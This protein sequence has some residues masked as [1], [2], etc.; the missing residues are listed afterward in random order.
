MRKPLRVLTVEDSEN[1]ALLLVRQLERG[2]FDVDFKRVDTPEAMNEA[3]LAQTWDI[4]L[5]DHVMPNFSAPAALEVLRERDFDL[6]FIIV[7]GSISAELAVALMKAG[8]HDWISKDDL[9]RLVPVVE[10]ELRDVEDRRKRREAEEGLRRNEQRLRSLFETMTEGVVLIAPDGQIVQANATAEQILGLTRSEIEGRSYVAPEWAIIRPDGTPMPAEEMVGPRAMAER[11]S[12]RD[13]VMGVKRPDG[14]IVWINVSAAPLI[15]KSGELEG[16]VGTFTDITARKKAEEE[17]RKSE[18]RFRSIV[19]TTKEWI[20]IQDLQG[21]HTYNSPALKA[22]L[23]YSP[24]EFPEQD[25]MMLIHE[26]DRRKEEE[27]FQKYMAE[28]KGWTGWVSRWKNKDGT[29]RYLESAATPLFDSKGELT[30]YLGAERDIT[31]RIKAEEALRESEELYRTL[32]DTSPDAITLTDLQGKIVIC[33]NQTARLH[34]YGNPEAIQ[35]LAAFELIAPED[36]EKALTNLR[37]TLET[38]SVR[39]LEYILLRKDGSRFRGELSAAVLRDAAGNP[40]AFVG[41]TRD[42]TERKK[43]RDELDRLTTL[44]DET[45]S[46]ALVG[47][48]EIDVKNNTLFWT[49]ETYRIHEI[50]PSEYMPTVDTAIAFYAPESVPIIR[51]AVQKALEK[52]EEFNLELE[53]ITAK[54]RRISVQATSKAIWENGQI[55]K[56]LGAFQDI[57]ERKEAELELLRR[58][59]AAE[60]A[61]LKAQTYLDF[62]SHDLTNILSPVMM[63]S[64]MISTDPRSHPWVKETAT[65]V[66]KQIERAVS[67]VRNTRRLSESERDESKR[68]ETV[69]LLTVLRT[70]EEEIRKMYPNKR[71]NFERSLPSDGPVNAM[72][73]SYIQ[74]IIDEILDN[75]AKHG[76]SND[77]RI[78]ITVHPIEKLE[79]HGYWKVEIADYGPGIPDDMKKG[80][81]AEVFEP[82]NRMTRGIASSLSFMALVAEHI[83]GRLRIEDRVQGD[84][85]KG[86]KV[87]LLFRKVG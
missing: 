14:V 61:T 24:D 23:G 66:V 86:T 55:V 50:S 22:I 54:G 48:W 20:W 47:G 59:E 49:S 33:S 15:D 69:D 18:E 70:K 34:G 3:L 78:D 9:S 67:F 81:M 29:Y 27:I 31:D 57:T 71:F 82:S 10:R 21:R 4:I 44:L 52:G 83:D 84:H 12:V 1:D 56:V 7:S 73:K 32:V 72:G 41:I 8:A 62:I 64:E 75:A 5:C 16:V 6:P 76:K 36:H 77:V 17:L 43:A 28:K 13:I 19:E 45:Q 40:K 30:G 85:T 53:L 35:G 63:Y 25:Y 42:I 26:D 79:G 51:A 46:L 38:G 65:K 80:L 68:V 74:D 37:R 39:N 11:R 58:K 87:V 2:G 60:A